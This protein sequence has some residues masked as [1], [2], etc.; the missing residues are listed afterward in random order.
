MASDQTPRANPG[1]A[2]RSTEGALAPRQALVRLEQI[3]KEL[4]PDHPRLVTTLELLWG[5]KACRQYLERLL[6]A[7]RDPDA[8][9]S[10]SFAP[11]AMDR[12][13]ALV[14]LHRIL[15]E[16]SDARPKP[17]AQAPPADVWVER[18]KFPRPLSKDQFSVEEKDSDTAW[19]RFDEASRLELPKIQA[20]TEKYAVSREYP[21]DAAGNPTFVGSQTT[22]TSADSSQAGSGR[23]ARAFD[24]TVPMSLSAQDRAQPVDPASLSSQTAKRREHAL[25]LIRAA[26]PQL[27][28]RIEQCWGQEA[29]LEDL[30]RMVLDRCDPENPQ[31]PPFSTKVLAALVDLISLHPAS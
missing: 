22:R 15:S 26:H 21:V 29:N 9:G 25:S 13:R 28:D 11:Q 8:A 1:A 12:L 16:V 10:A 31:S 3:K 14:E 6:A 5:Q 27:A 7:G 30:K 2:Q 24:H 18:R 20:K 19:G 4:R 23:L 17:G